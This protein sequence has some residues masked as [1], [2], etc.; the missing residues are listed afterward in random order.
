MMFVVPK[1]VEQF[2]TVGQTLPLLTRIVIAIS[3]V[4]ANWWWLIFGLIALALFAGWQI[5]QQ[6]G[7]RTRFDGWLL[8]LP[9]VEVDVV[10]DNLN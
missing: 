8:R 3:D 2:D 9:C 7:P 1:V 5:L 6:E 4:L 10:P